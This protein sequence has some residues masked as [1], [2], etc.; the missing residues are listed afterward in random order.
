MTELLEIAERHGLAVVE[1][2]AQ[3]IGATH[4]GRQ[5]GTL[6]TAGVLSLNYHKIIH[7]GEGGI[8]LTDD[9]EVARIAQLSRNHGE[10]V[11]DQAGLA[12]IANTIGSNFRMTE[13]EAAIAFTQLRKLD[14]LL[15][16]RRGLAARMTER[17]DGIDG[18][19]G[20]MI[21][22]G[23]TH[24]F[25]VYPL[26]LE[27]EV[28]DAVPRSAVV[29][30]L[31][32]EGIPVS[33]G[34][35]TPL[36]LQPMYQQRISRGTRGCPWTC[37]HWT[38]DVSYAKGICPVTERL[39]ERELMLVDVT[40]SPLHNRRRR[41]CRGRAGEGPRR[42]RRATP[43]RRRG[44]RMTRAAQHPRRRARRGCRRGSGARGPRD[45]RQGL[46]YPCDR[47]PR[48][49]RNGLRARGPAR[50]GSR[51]R[52]RRPSRSTRCWSASVCAAC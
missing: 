24:S 10:V 19:R 38:G 1:D 6:G 27:D 37:G 29:R 11:A 45:P 51:R 14:G 44:S 49:G 16:L 26:R 9:D 15:E 39:H 32:A 21:A 30:A 7:S 52:S 35:V 20:A 41:R 22:E 25:Y 46:V 18:V 34:Y 40:R 3:S 23:C 50:A 4:H 2:A 5:T 17:L 47:R 8:V 43:D 33:N 28:L 12:G 36:Y 48:Q 31:A 42:P 13:I